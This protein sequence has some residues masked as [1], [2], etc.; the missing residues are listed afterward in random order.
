MT[1]Y[2]EL[3]EYLEGMLR[4]KEKELIEEHA[5][6]DAV[7]FAITSL[8]DFL[9][10]EMDIDTDTLEVFLKDAYKDKLEDNLSAVA[11]LLR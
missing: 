3:A 7:E 6:M 11:S 4:G 9:K 2:Q 10:H 5:K 1:N 8:L